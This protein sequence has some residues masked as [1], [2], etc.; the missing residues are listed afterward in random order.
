MFS[1]RAFEVQVDLV[2]DS[3]VASTVKN[4]VFPNGGKSMLDKEFSLVNSILTTSQYFYQYNKIYLAPTEDIAKLK[5]D[6]MHE[7]THLK[8]SVRLGSMI[9]FLWD[10]MMALRTLV[11]LEQFKHI[12]SNWCLNY[13]E[14][15]SSAV[16]SKYVFLAEIFCKVNSRYKRLIELSR[17]IQ[18]GVATFGSIDQEVTILDNSLKIKYEEYR[19]Q[20]RRNLQGIYKTYY[21]KSAEISK[22]FGRMWPLEMAAISLDIPYPEFNIITC[23]EEEFNEYFEKFSPL[24]RWELLSQLN[25]KD[26]AQLKRKMLYK[27]MSY[28][29]DLDD[30]LGGDSSISKQDWMINFFYLDIE[31]YKPF[32]SNGFSIQPK[33]LFRLMNC[34]IA[35]IDEFLYHFM[36]V[37]FSV[38]SLYLREIIGELKL[39]YGNKGPLF[40]WGSENEGKVLH[41]N[42]SLNNFVSLLEVINVANMDIQREHLENV[43]GGRIG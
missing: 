6:Y 7:Y 14:F 36:T 2:R 29:E 43:I 39:P 3:Y 12:D 35:D 42:F 20:C 5:I 31:I 22:Y 37:K 18:E 4:I 30:I 16:T 17:P 10:F 9:K 21:D 33:Q 15:P 38:Y 25:H 28:Y 1:L 13:D 26:V 23:T 40:Y 27:D 32:F 11:V 8:C 24:S 34:S 19:N 41:D